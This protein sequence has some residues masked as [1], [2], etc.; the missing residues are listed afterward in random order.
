MQ[1]LKLLAS[2]G[3]RQR[4]MDQFEWGWTA[5][6]AIARQSVARHFW[7]QINCSTQI[8]STARIQLILAKPDSSKWP[9]NDTVEQLTLNFFATVKCKSSNFFHIE[10]VNNFICRTC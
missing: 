10:M 5:R 1:K 6:N 8:L 9:K 2:E 4:R 3:I 7:Q